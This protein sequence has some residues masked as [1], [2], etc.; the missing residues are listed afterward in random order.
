MAQRMPGQK[1]Y[2]SI[3][4]QKSPQKNPVPDGF[5]HEQNYTQYDG[6]QCIHH[7]SLEA[8]GQH[9][10]HTIM[11]ASPLV[12]AYNLSSFKGILQYYECYDMVF[13]F[14]ER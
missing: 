8:I 6:Y 7:L 3:E 13:C 11:P 4:H 9:P 5:Q 2:D 12:I 10:M 14:C 1:R